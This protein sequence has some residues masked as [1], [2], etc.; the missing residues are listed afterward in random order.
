MQVR[1]GDQVTIVDLV[2]KPELNGRT[3]VCEKFDAE[4]GRWIIRVNSLNSVM[5]LLPKNMRMI[6]K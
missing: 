5:Q 1:A 6:E 2:S 3:G 4:S